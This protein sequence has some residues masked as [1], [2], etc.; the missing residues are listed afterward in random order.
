MAFPQ[1]VSTILGKSKATIFQVTAHIYWTHSTPYN[2]CQLKQYCT[3][4]YNTVSLNSDHTETIRKQF[5]TLE[6]QGYEK[7][8]QHSSLSET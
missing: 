2:F 8:V 3:V 6:K 5:T 4:L 7:H 1:Y